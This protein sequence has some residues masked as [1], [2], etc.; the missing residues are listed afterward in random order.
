M[1][2]AEDV[3]RWPA[4]AAVRSASS[5]AR[6][7]GELM[8][9]EQLVMLDSSAFTHVCPTSFM[10]EV[11]M[12]C[13]KPKQGC[14]TASGH[15]LI[16]YGSKK[17]RIQVWGDVVMEVTFAVMDVARP[18]LSVGGLQHHGWSIHSG[19]HSYFER[20]NKV[21]PLF[22]RGGLS[23][24][25][26]KARRPQASWSE[27]M[28]EVLTEVAKHAKELDVHREEGERWHVVEY[29]C[30]EDSLLTEYFLRRG[31]TGTQLG[32]PSWDLSA[33]AGA[34]RAVEE[35][36]QQLDQGKKIL[37]WAALPCTP[38]CTWKRVNE[39]IGEETRRR[40]ENARAHSLVMIRLFKYVLRKTLEMGGERIVAAYEWP[41]AATGWQLPEMR[42]LVKLLPHQC[43]FDGCQYGLTTAAGRLKKPWRVQAN[44]A[45]LVEPL[46][47]RCGGEH[48]H[49]T[50]RGAAAVRSGLYTPAMVRAIGRA[51]VG[52]GQRE[53]NP[54]L[55][56]EAAP[57]DASKPLQP[58]TELN[59]IRNPSELLEEAA[60][61]H[62]AGRP[63]RPPECS[64]QDAT[65]TPANRAERPQ[66]PPECS[67]QDA[68]PANRAERPQEP[69]MPGEEEE[70]AAEEQVSRPV[71]TWRAT[72][73]PT[74]VQRQARL[75][76]HVPYAAWCETCACARSR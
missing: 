42:E 51:V 70:V 56:K 66:E 46:G 59:M 73:K 64:A 69:P 50:L 41:R 26:V 36:R 8:S 21:M 31:H 39:Q 17:V 20:G 54:V 61:S 65:A 23:Y 38:R 14:L 30:E 34:R 13:S 76:T 55:L 18:L 58:E 27:S 35:V 6:P 71:V 32:L 44:A 7:V 12:E 60:G 63:R 47:R 45:R 43:S 9:Y 5:M 16:C 72:D 57:G 67:A 25:A 28:C 49:V 22:R 3:D 1:N 29:C 48:P 74:E 2:L 19:Q 4:D 68:A 24:L 40:L 53:I 52:C 37:F 15:P 62:K 11:A 10:P 75:I 33:M